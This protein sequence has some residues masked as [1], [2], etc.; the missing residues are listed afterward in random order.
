MDTRDSAG[1]DAAS[2]LRALQDERSVLSRELAGD[3][4]HRR[5]Q[6]GACFLVL[7]RFVGDAGG[8]TTNEAL[9]EL[10]VGR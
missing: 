6:R 5:E 9:G 7:D 10:G 1:Q 3:L 8:A 2:T 4:A